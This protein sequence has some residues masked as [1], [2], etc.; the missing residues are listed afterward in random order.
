MW[1]APAAWD[2]VSPTIP[3]FSDDATSEDA[4][5]P[6]GFHSFE[7]RWVLADAFAFRQAIGKRSRRER[8]HDPNRRLKDASRRWATSSC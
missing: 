4:M 1:G 3:S 2:R 6:G 7:H 5:T 8:T